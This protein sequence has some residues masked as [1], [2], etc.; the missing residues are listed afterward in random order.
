MLMSFEEICSPPYRD[1]FVKYPDKRKPKKHL[2]NFIRLF[3]NNPN[4]LSNLE[5]NKLSNNTVIK[6]RIKS[7]VYLVEVARQFFF[8]LLLRH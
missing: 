2:K 3:R 4:N 1:G 7:H 8:H 5:G 6:L